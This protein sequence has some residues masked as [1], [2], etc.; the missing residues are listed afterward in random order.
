MKIEDVNFSVR[1]YHVLK[2]AGINTTE[3]VQRMTDDDLLRLRNVGVRCVEEIRSKLPYIPTELPPTRS[4][5]DKIRA[6]SDEEL[7]DAIFRLIYALDPAT[8][9]C[10]GKKEC[11]D[12]MDADKEI[13]DAMCKACL[14]AKLRQPAEETPRPVRIHEDKQESGLLEDD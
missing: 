8:W 12:L 13:P 4:I 10:K 3:E 5:A 1:T 6:M 11:G 9:F 7:C 2:R 14:L